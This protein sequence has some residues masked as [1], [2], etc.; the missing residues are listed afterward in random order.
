[1]IIYV[2]KEIRFTSV[3]MEH[4]AG[5]KP[6]S[7]CHVIRTQGRQYLAVDFFGLAGIHYTKALINQRGVAC[8]RLNACVRVLR[9]ILSLAINRDREQLSCTTFPSRRRPMQN[10]GLSRVVRA[11][12]TGAPADR[13]FQNRVLL[14]LGRWKQ[15]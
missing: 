3:E 9:L 4:F 2:Q 13:Y 7:F 8:L 6:S 10:L 1:M 14:W 12:N 11:K 15:V 5:K